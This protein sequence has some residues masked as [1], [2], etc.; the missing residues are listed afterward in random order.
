MAKKIFSQVFN[1]NYLVVGK[2]FFSSLEGVE[3]EK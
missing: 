1:I 3:S 2:M